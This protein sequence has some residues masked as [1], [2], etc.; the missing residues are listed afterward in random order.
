MLSQLPQLAD[1]TLKDWSLVVARANSLEP[2]AIVL[3]A[4]L[5][6]E[7]SDAGGKN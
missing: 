6:Q 4:A 1:P 5:V 2:G 7:A 3:Q